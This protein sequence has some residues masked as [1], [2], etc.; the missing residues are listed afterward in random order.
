MIT[1]LCSLLLASGK[2]DSVSL[3]FAFF[4]CNRIEKKDWEETRDANP[5]SANLPQL[6][7][8]FR[9]LAQMKRVPSLVFAGGDLVMNYIDDKGE[10]L[11]EQLKDWQRVFWNSPLAGKCIL[12]PFPGNHE[13]NKKVGDMKL[14]NPLT[15][16]VWNRWYAQS[17]FRQLGFNGPLGKAGNPDRVVGD[18]SRLNYSFDVHHVHFVVLN[19]DTTTSV[20]DPK[21]G[22]PTVGW[23]PAEWARKDIERAQRDPSVKAI[24]VTGHRN[25]VDGK[26]SKGDAP[27]APAAGVKLLNALRVNKKVRAYVCAHVHAWDVVN[28]GG[29]SKAWQVIAGNGGSKLESDW[30]PAGGTFFGFAVLDVYKSGKV[31]LHNYRRPTPSGKYSD[32][33]PKPEPAKPVDTVL[34][35]PVK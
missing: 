29:A 30:A 34:Y 8:T 14:P 12:V 21:T 31:V 17:G 16:P 27:I 28:L 20:L 23:I 2:P 18:Q 6:N 33:T 32:G 4:G 5:S 22:K 15:L 19:T 7:R 35:D 3:S 13:V 25:L 26:T 10:V 24:F 11:W 1:L 9:D